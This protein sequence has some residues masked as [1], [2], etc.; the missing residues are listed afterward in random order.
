MEKFHYV[1]CIMN[2]I[3]KKFYIGRRSSKKHPNL[4]PYFG[5]GLALKAAI[6]KYGKRNF[7]KEIIEICDDFETLCEREVYYISYFEAIK[8]GYNISDMSLGV[9][10]TG[11]SHPMFGKTHTDEAKKKIAEANKG[12]QNMVGKKLSEEWKN[13]IGSGVKGEKNGMFGKTHTVEVR[14]RIGVATGKRRLGSKH[15]EETIKKMSESAKNRKK[16]TC[17]HCG[18]SIVINVYKRYHGDNCKFKK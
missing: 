1:Y 11:D 12:N 5:S 17:P 10:L 14:K 9:S 15:S 4:D 18:K 13:N 2:N 3:N 8:N 16:L 6:L 7:T